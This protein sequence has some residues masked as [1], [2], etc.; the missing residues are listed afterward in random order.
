M[1]KVYSY[2]MAVFFALLAMVSFAACSSDDDSQQIY[3][4]GVSYTDLSGAIPKAWGQIEAAYDAKLGKASP[5]QG[6]SDAK[7]KALAEEAENTITDLDWE[8]TTGM[9]TYSIT[10]INTGKT[11]YSR[12]FSSDDGGNQIPKPPK[13]PK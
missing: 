5:F 2:I 7:V 12:T 1:K 11:I 9:L 8:E 3:T 6:E 13:F 4:K 10:N